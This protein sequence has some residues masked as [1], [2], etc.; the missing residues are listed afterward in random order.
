MLDHHGHH[1]VLLHQA[2]PAATPGLPVSS[3]D[4]HRHHTVLLQ[5]LH[6][7]Y[8]SLHWTTVDTTHFCFIRLQLQLVFTCHLAG[9]PWTPHSAASS[10]SGYSWL[11]CLFTGPPWISHSSASLG[12]S[13]TWLTCL[14]AGPPWA[15]HSSPSLGSGYT[16]PT[17]LL[18]GPLWTPH[19]S[20]S[21]SGSYPW[22][23]CLFTRLPQSG[24]QSNRHHTVLLQQAAATPSLPVSSP[25]Y[26]RVVINPTDTT[27]FCFSRQR[28]HLAYL[29]PCWTIMDTTQFCFS[30]QR[31]HLAYLS[32]CWTTMGTT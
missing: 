23:T 18:A 1:T 26:H 22:L 25:D 3:L 20:A 15:P 30:R 17:C 7:A 14:L 32:P 11:T 6:L 10:G 31:L 24:H 8:L 13:Y 12:S 19:S 4:H 27:Q 29:S 28:L 5:R 21:L 2:V 9:L 16:W